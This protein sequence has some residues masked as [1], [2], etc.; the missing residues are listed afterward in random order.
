MNIGPNCVLFLS[1]LNFV[2]TKRRGGFV[3]TE[4]DQAPTVVNGAGVTEAAI[5]KE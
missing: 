4:K 2:V 3:R 5:K 1:I